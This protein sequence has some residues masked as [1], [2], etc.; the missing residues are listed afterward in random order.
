MKYNKVIKGN[1][2]LPDSNFIDFNEIDDP[3]L[4]QR[5]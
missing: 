5:I 2:I 1:L 4:K 3:I